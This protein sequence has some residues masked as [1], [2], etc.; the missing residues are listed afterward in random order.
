MTTTNEEGKNNKPHKKGLIEGKDDLVPV[1]ELVL[2]LHAPEAELS[3]G[4]RKLLARTEIAID[5]AEG[6]RQQNLLAT[7]HRTLQRRLERRIPLG[8]QL[9]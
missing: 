8:R 1:H 5:L 3:H 2:A 6:F 7:A 9:A 4:A